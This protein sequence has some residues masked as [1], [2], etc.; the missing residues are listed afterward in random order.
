MLIALATAVFVL[1]WS[2]G[3]IVAKYVVPVADP[4]TFLAIR[5][6]TAMLVLAGMAAVMRAPWPKTRAEW[7]HSMVT[8]VFIHAIYLAA[9]WWVIARGLPA[10]ISALIA[11]TQPLITAGLAPRLLGEKLRPVNLAGILVGF[12]GV[13]GVLAPKLEG[14]AFAGVGLLVLI[15]FAG[16]ISVTLGTFYQ[17]KYVPSG[18]LRTGTAIQYLA[19]FLVIL[20]LAWFTE[21]MRFEPVAE[22]WYALLWSVLVLS[23]GA[24][25]LM[26]WM[27]RR[28]AV[29]K[30][31]SLIY[32]V[33]PVAA[34]QAYAMFGERLL[35]SQMVF[36]GVAA[37]GVY[38]ANRK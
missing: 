17:K 4:L 35:P 8:G 12:L 24:I 13:M 18:D 25:L 21:P 15:N 29:S 32:L 9:V 27:I 16:M 14:A 22:S 7:V 37:F 11:A 20:P 6:G 28:G 19:A 33:P 23:I 34:L 38:L 3:W 5:F 2:T 36:M 31:A 10:G 1:I 30:L 26:L